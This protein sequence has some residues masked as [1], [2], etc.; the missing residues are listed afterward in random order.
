M[1][2]RRRTWLISTIAVVVFAALA[3]VVVRALW[4]TASSHVAESCT[5]GGYDLDTD[6]AS[7]AASMTAAV[8]SYPGALPDRAADL[9]LAAGL[10]ESK[11]RNL[12]PGAGDR[13][14][15]GVLQQR[16]SQGWGDGDV[17]KLENVFTATTEFLQHLV[18]VPDWQQLPLAD[19][20]QAVQISADGSAYAQHETEAHALGQALLG[21]Q[22]QAVSC[23]FAK[24]T[25]IATPAQVITKLTAELPVNS[26]TVAGAA[27]SVPGAGWQ[28]VN[29]LV[30]YADRLG[31]DSVAFDG[32]IWSR[33]N[34]WRTSAASAT[35]VVAAM[36]PPPAR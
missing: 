12:P 22:P 26:P 36:A 30:S 14:S 13:D 2:R 5:V 33:A 29:W 4:D 21:R 10:Q 17:T 16:P 1:A 7:V 28:T 35:A 20:V 25:L 15:V 6:Q 19:A 31:I 8:V 24:P 23:Q 3:V 11:L 34:G 27:I 18:K 9:A 32:H